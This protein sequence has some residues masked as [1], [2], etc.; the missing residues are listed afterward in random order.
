MG[1]QRDTS[2]LAD[3]PGKLPRPE[4]RVPE[5]TANLRSAR[6]CKQTNEVRTAFTDGTFN[7][8]EQ[9]GGL[10]VIFPQTPDI[11]VPL[12][13]C[14]CSLEAELYALWYALWA[15]AVKKTLEIYTDSYSGI[16]AI[17]AQMEQP[18][19]RKATRTLRSQYLLDAVCD[20]IGVR[21]LNAALTHLAVRIQPS[22]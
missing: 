10:S 19:L 8:A 4:T 18:A 7:Q 21:K 5:G 11:L 1:R 3:N 14:G 12:L 20:Y 9:S 17:T 15:V 6:Y 2:S 16:Q 13:K 22:A